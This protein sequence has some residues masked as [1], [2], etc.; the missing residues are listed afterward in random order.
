M[1]IT[2]LVVYR[3]LGLA[4]LR[5]R[6]VNFDM[7]WAVALFVVGATALYHATRMATA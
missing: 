7:I 6:W 3:K 2:A 4:I 1:L 5:R